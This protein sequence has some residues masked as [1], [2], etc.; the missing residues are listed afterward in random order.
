MGSNRRNFIKGL[1][2]IGASATAAALFT[3]DSLAAIDYDAET[4][5]PRIHGYERVNTEEIRN[6]GASPVYEPI[7][8]S[9]P[10]E[11]WVEV[12]TAHDARERVAAR[13]SDLEQEPRV[14]VG[15]Q[16]S[17]GKPRRAIVVEHETER[18]RD[19]PRNRRPEMSFDEF[20]DQVKELIPDEV[21]G[22]AGR[23][24]DAETTVESIPL[25]IEQ[26]EGAEHQWDYDHEY[27]S[28]GVPAGCYIHNGDSAG[29]LGPFMF[30]SHYGEW[31]FLTAAH[32]ANGSSNGKMYQNDPVSN[33]HFADVNW[34]KTKKDGSFDASVLNHLQFGGSWDFA[35]D[36]WDSYQGPTIEGRQSMSG[37]KDMEFS[38][39]IYKQ[40]IATG[41]SSGTVHNVGSNSF[42]TD[43]DEDNGDSG[44]PYWVEKSSGGAL[45]SGI[46]Y[47]GTGFGFAYGTIMDV[48]VDEFNLSSL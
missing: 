45:A 17:R 33:G 23:G 26:V 35:A 18:S 43:C 47:K 11:K 6:E 42:K 21:H 16:T 24:T 5:V 7:Y 41:R 14:A 25:K 44:G 30:D 19:G 46:H 3:K 36:S 31:I 2:G 39:T 37:L 9:I 1:L 40:G 29:T 20:S 48:I 8:E 10:R 27:R 34:T 4:E 15:W 38:G 28:E 12:E 13:L 22:T 32:V